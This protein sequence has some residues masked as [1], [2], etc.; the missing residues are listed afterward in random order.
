MKKH[1]SQWNT[2]RS[3]L[4]KSA[5]STL[6]LSPFAPKSMI[7]FLI[8][9]S[10]HSSQQYLDP[11]AAFLTDLFNVLRSTK[12]A[13]VLGLDDQTEQSWTEVTI[14]N[15]SVVIYHDHE[16]MMPN[17]PADSYIPVSFGF[18]GKTEGYTAHGRCKKNHR[19]T[20]KPSPPPPPPPGNPAK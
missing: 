11:P 6:V 15:A 19:H 14:G 1:W 3:L 20:S 10:W 18:D 4:S 12:C 7:V 9:I 17:A 5:L 16:K 13:G 8:R 2:P